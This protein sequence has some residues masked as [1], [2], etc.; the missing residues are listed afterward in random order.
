[1]KPFTVSFAIDSLNVHMDK[2]DASAYYFRKADFTLDDG[3]HMV[4][5]FL[6]SAT[7]NKE[8]SNWKLRFLHS[9]ERK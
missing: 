9:S 1:M 4:V 6:E 3:V 2:K 8:G 5:K 7:F